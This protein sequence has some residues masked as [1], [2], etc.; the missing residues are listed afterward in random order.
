MLFVCDTLHSGD[1]NNG[2]VWYSN[3]WH[4][5]D[6]HHNSKHGDLNSKLIVSYS[7]HCLKYLTKSLNNVQLKVGYSD[8]SS[9]HIFVI[10]IPTFDFYIKTL[11]EITSRRIIQQIPQKQKELLV[12]SKLIILQILFKAWN[13]C[14]LIFEALKK[15]YQNKR[16]C[17]CVTSFCMGLKEPFSLSNKVL[18]PI[19]VFCKCFLLL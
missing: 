6:Q 10:Q 8:V 16:V 7:D 15:F 13:K 5:S 11:A 17:D 2:L 18:C 14:H 3:Y 19:R 4:V 9:V 1:L 12:T